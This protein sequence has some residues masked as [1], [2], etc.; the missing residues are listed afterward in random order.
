[1]P[2]TSLPQ[3]TTPRSDEAPL[4]RW[5]ILGPGWIADQMAAAMRRRTT[6]I[7]QAVASRDLARAEDFA[8]RW[9]VGSA[10]GSYEQLVADPRIDV[11]YVATPHHLHLPH[12]L[13]A[14]EAGKH[15]LI[16]K[17]VGLDAGEARAIDAAA[18]AAGVFAMEAMWT[19]FLPKYDVIRQLLAD[20]ALGRVHTV[21][22]DMGEAFPAG[23]RI[24]RADLAGGPMLDLGTYPATIISWFL[25][26]D[27]R[28]AGAVAQ[29]VPAG[30]TGAGGA[31]DGGAGGDIGGR[32]DDEGDGGTGPGLNGEI[33]ATLTGA[34]TADA[35]GQSGGSGRTAQFHATI[36]GETPTRASI[37]GDAGAL[38]IDRHFY[39]PGPF[40]VR[41]AGAEPLT[42]DEPR[43]DHDGLH[44]EVAETARRIAAGEQG[45]PI[46]PFTDTIATLEL[47]DSIRAAVGVDFPQ[48]RAAREV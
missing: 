29:N 9:E 19:L 5:G 17:P 24:F 37:V 4:L 33:S 46:R 18:A 27:L 13:L 45:S 43:V 35:A 42:W 26:A 12:A 32:T 34:G 8:Q 38:W 23:H 2:I 3:P 10:Y 14:I 21:L 40:T 36:L 6:Q 28:V 48:A 25:G 20:G 15:V 39:R 7:L 30:M 31:G 11:V 22:A 47:M 44:F 1:M 41:Q 16:E